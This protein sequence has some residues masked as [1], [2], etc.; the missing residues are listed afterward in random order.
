MNVPEHGNKPRSVVSL[1]T[2]L[3]CF[4]QRGGDILYM[5]Y[6][7]VC[8][9]T[10]SDGQCSS[11]QILFGDK[12]RRA[13]TGNSDRIIDEIQQSLL[14]FW[15][16]ALKWALLLSSFPPTTFPSVEWL[17]NDRIF[18]HTIS[19]KQISPFYLTTAAFEMPGSINSCEILCCGSQGIGTRRW[20]CADGGLLHTTLSLKL[21][22]G[23]FFLCW[24]SQSVIS[25]F[26]KGCQTSKCQVCFDQAKFCLHKVCCCYIGK[27]A[28]SNQFFVRF[29]AKSM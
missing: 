10:Q 19:T 1:C 9:C 11:V 20:V 8:I 26:L 6:V 4:G 23:L 29:M 27:H 18:W 17:S 14:K 22:P 16:P 2:L 3:L 21:S 7:S 5:D 15:V 13:H 12:D 28:K 24:A 25:Y